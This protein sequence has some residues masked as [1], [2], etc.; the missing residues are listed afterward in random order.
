MPLTVKVKRRT[1]V[2]GIS[3]KKGFGSEVR[4]DVLRAIESRHSVRQFTDQPITGQALER[5][6]AAIAEAN[7]VAGLHFQLVLDEPG[8]FSGL[9]AYYGRFRN[10]RNYIALVGPDSPGL[11]KVCG[12]HGE[13]IVLIAQDAGLSTCWVGGTF[14]RRK[15]HFD[16]AEGERFCILIAIGYAAEEATPHKSKD[17]ARLCRAN[18]QETPDWFDRGMQAVLLA[19]TAMNQQRFVFSFEGNDVV[20]AMSLGGP[21]ADIDLGIAIYHFEAVSCHAVTPPHFPTPTIENG[22]SSWFRRTHCRPANTLAS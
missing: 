15:A 20:R 1:V 5:L 11:D 7:Q 10:V 14:N 4:M 6:E 8:A 21:F 16:V 22:I 18:G 2:R 9:L 13:R 17:L 3:L 19:P 12:Y